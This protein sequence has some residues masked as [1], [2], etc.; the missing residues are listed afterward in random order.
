VVFVTA[1]AHPVGLAPAREE[2]PAEALEPDLEVEAGLGLP[3][4]QKTSQASTG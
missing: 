4:T 3:C 2:A 1:L